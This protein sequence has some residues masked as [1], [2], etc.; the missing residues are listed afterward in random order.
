[1]ARARSVGVV[2]LG[3]V[4]IVA[5]S[6]ITDTILENAGVIPK[7]ALPMR[8]SE[9]VL[10]G[11]LGYRALYSLIGCYITARLAPSNP[12]KHALALGALGVILSALGSD[13]TSGKAPLWYDVILVVMALPIAWLGGKLQQISTKNHKVG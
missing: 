10:V 12:M 9:L 7:G 4:I 6:T 8:G 2:I 5:L 3:F 1:M 13:V 11:I